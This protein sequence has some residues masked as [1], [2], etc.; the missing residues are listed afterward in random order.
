MNKNISLF[1]KG[2]LMGVAD[3]IPGVSGGTLA[4]IVGIYEK[5]IAEIGSIDLRLFFQFKL[6]RFFDEF[7]YKFL[8]ILFCGVL[9]SFALFSRLV[10]FLLENHPKEIFSSFLG[11]ILAATLIIIMRYKL[12]SKYYLMI[13]ILSSILTWI[14]LGV[15]GISLT[16]NF[17]MIFI[18]GII[19]SSAMILPG[20]SG[21][22]ILVLLGMYKF[23]I[24]HIKSLPNLESLLIAGV[25]S[26]GVLIGILTMS[27]IL[28]KLFNWKPELVLSLLIGV[29]IGG[30]RKIWPWTL[31]ASSQLRL[32]SLGQSAELKQLGLAVGCFLILVCLELFVK[33]KEN[34]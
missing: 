31:E 13:V 10:H 3:I 17:P 12:W 20:I 15:G 5:L 22:Y 23:M 9:T 27:K 1:L 6:K 30:I 25:F 11:L 28:K 34:I 7:D 21:S 18:S 16:P 24:G 14:A 33:R 4:L 32:P 19:A 8:G 29:V 2:I 26:L